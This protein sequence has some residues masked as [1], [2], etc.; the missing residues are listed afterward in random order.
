MNNPGEILRLTAMA[1]PHVAVI[2][3]AGA[4]HLEG[5][6]DLPG[7]ARAKG[8]ILSGLDARGVAVL[9]ADDEYFPLWRQQLGERHMISFGGS[10]RADVRGERQE[11]SK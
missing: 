8:E 5:F 4:A 9:N 11:L 7:V 3:N 6:G 1:R 2:T 10:P